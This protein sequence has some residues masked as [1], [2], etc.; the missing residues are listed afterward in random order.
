MTMEPKK[1]SYQLDNYRKPTMKDPQSERI[2]DLIVV[3][4]GR[5]HRP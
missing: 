1:M 2:Y 4:A 5:A 3:G